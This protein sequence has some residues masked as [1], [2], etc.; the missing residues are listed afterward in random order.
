MWFLNSI[1]EF[2][3][4]SSRAHLYEYLNLNSVFFLII[5]PINKSNNYYFQIELI[6]LFILLTKGY[7]FFSKTLVFDPI[8]MKFINMFIER[9]II[10]K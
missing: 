4:K 2:P 7:E 8:G 6:F 10:G 9:I 1:N 3:I 5:K